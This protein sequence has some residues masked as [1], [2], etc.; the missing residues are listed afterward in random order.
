MTEIA[1]KKNQL[2]ATTVV[3]EL[4]RLIY[5]GEL[6]PGSRLNEAALAL[7]MGTSRGPIREAIRILAGHGLV[8]SIAHRGMF[9]RQMTVRDMLESYDLRALIFGFAARRATE[10]LTPERRQRLEEQLAKMETA[11]AANDGSLYYELNLH[12]HELILEFSNNRHAAKAYDEYVNELH[13]FRRR[14]FNYTN[15]MQRSNAEHRA[16]VDAILD[17]NATLAEELAEQHVLAGKQRLLE[18]L[19]GLDMQ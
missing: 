14:F 16:I 18:N 17:G 11:T 2:L 7:K 5:S 12:F 3:D 8:T 9:V 1:Q 13:L 15:K 10:Y 4:K 6:E 19:D